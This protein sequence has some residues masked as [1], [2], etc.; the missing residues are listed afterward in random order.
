[1]PKIVVNRCWGGFGLSEEAYQALGLAWDGY[2][3]AYNEYE[4]RSDPKLVEVVER[5]GEKASGELASL[6]VVSVPDDVSW[7]I[8]DDDGQETVRERHR[9]W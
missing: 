9:S 7:E 3:N 2:G 1:M 6:R 8:A 5:L 4:K